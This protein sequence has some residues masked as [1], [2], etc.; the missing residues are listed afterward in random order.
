MGELLEFLGS[1]DREF[2]PRGHCGDWNPLWRWIYCA[3]AVA[4][5]LSCVVI[6]A[7][8]AVA[9]SEEVAE[10]SGF[11]DRR[12]VRLVFA[13]LLVL[14]AAKHAEDLLAFVAPYYHVFAVYNLLVAV[15]SISA[16]IFAITYRARL[17][18]GF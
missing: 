6:A 8:L 18:A 16:T 12:Q 5:A 3:S 7:T 11:P 4:N 17:L 13:L 1:I 15:A 14:Y 10:A 2:M 9:P